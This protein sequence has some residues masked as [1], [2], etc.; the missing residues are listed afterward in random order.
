MSAA[1]DSGTGLDFLF[2]GEVN[3]PDDSGDDTVDINGSVGVNIFLAA[4]Y[5]SLVA[6]GRV[7]AYI[8]GFENAIG[9]GAADALI[10]DSRNNA[11]DGQ[12]GADWLVGGG[13]ADRFSFSSASQAAGDQVA[14]FSRIEGDKIDLRT[15]DANVGTVFDDPF[16][17]STTR[18]SNLVSELVFT[19]FGAAGG[20][21]DLYVNA[22]I[23]PTAPSS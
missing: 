20:R 23:S 15:I 2:G 22:D 5:V 21:V 13:G 4:G 18:T 8:S 6:A 3:G 9:D 11:L 16:T 14:D 17:F 7:T 12:G 10:G 1:A 19:S